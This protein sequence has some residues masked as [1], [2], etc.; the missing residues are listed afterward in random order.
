MKLS[1]YAQKE[2]L[3][4]RTALRYFHKGIIIGIQLPTGSILVEDIPLNSTAN[5][6]PKIAALYRLEY[7]AGDKKYHHSQQVEL[8]TYATDRGYTIG[9][10]VMETESPFGSSRTKLL[11]LFKDTWDVLVIKHRGQL[12]DFDQVCLSAYAQNLGRSVEIISP[13]PVLYD[14]YDPNDWYS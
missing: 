10:N 2:G 12:N 13:A 7:N 5:A 6:A 8:E 1:A 3:T 11:E 4:Y 9:P 14:G